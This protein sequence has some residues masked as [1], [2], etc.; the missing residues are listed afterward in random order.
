[1][2]EYFI[3]DSNQEI[4]EVW[5]E[6]NDHQDSLYKE[7]WF[8]VIPIFTGFILRDT[9]ISSILSVISESQDLETLSLDIEGD[10]YATKGSIGPQRMLVGAQI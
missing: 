6:F 4:L 10:L 3:C 9:E 1:M 5:I 2:S 8:I 7:S